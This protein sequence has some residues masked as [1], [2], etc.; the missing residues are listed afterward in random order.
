MVGAYPGGRGDVMETGADPRWITGRMKWLYSFVL[1]G[2]SFTRW[3]VWTRAGDV[4]IGEMWFEGGRWWVAHVD[5]EGIRRGAFVDA[6]SAGRL[7]RLFE[8]LERT[9]REFGKS[10]EVE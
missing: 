1:K 10:A 8:S 2:D 6:E 4:R 5:G 7:D 3:T 9:W